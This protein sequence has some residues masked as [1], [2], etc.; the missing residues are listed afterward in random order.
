M[1]F[2]S[3]YSTKLKTNSL[4]KTNSG[5]VSLLQNPS[6]CSEAKKVVHAFH[7][8]GLGC[9]LQTIL[10]S[11]T[12]AVVSNRTLILDSSLFR[13][14]PGEWEKYF[15]PM[16]ETCIDGGGSSRK[17]WNGKR[18]VTLTQQS[19]NIFKARLYC[20]WTYLIFK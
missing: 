11:L 9:C 4:T 1:F 18:V 3:N 2:C 12:L 14:A 15:L 16:S 13:Y 19:C 17:Q 6:N 8:C 5:H 10:R 7:P 20:I